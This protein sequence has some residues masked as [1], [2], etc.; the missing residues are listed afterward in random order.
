MIQVEPIVS[1][2]LQNKELKNNLYSVM[3]GFIPRSVLANKNRA[4]TWHYG[5][6]EKYD[7]IIISRSGQVGEVI[8]ISGLNVALPPPPKEIRRGLL[9]IIIYY[10]PI[11]LKIFNY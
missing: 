9:E 10:K 8:N 7:V 3:E 1:K 5:Y 11:R 4:K 6:N 2:G